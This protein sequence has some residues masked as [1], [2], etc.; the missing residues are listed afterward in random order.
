MCNPNTQLREQINALVSSDIGTANSSLNRLRRSKSDLGKDGDKLEIRVFD[1]IPVQSMFILDPKDESRGT[2]RVEP[3]LYSIRK[4]DRRIHEL[5][6]KNQ[7]KFFKTYWQ[8]YNEMWDS[9][10]PVDL[11]STS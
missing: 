4:E 9:S 1:G 10:N 3:Y 7:K 2:M 6:I 5:T 11:I 8:S